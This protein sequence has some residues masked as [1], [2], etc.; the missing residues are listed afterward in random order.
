M[1]SWAWLRAPCVPG[2]QLSPLAHISLYNVPPSP[3]RPASKLRSVHARPEA[4]ERRASA[5]KPE[6]TEHG[7]VFWTVDCC[8]R[9]RAWRAVGVQ[10]LFRGV[11]DTQ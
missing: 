7:D 8:A 4:H 1:G 3:I 10:H 6:A 5:A 2:T 9:N 11:N